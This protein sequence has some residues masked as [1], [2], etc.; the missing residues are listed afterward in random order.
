MTREEALTH[1]KRSNTQELSKEELVNKIYDNFE[2]EK[3]KWSEQLLD[4]ADK[5]LT[6]AQK[7]S[8]C[9]DRLIAYKKGG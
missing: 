2:E 8:D 5:H 3:L 7:Y 4:V 6:L 9:V 1:T